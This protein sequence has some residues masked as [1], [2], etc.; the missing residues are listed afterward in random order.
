[1]LLRRVFTTLFCLLVGLGGMQAHGAEATYSIIGPMELKD[2]VDSGADTFLVIDARNPEE[3][4]EVHIPG[5][6]NVPQKK[7]KANKHLLPADKN[8]LLILYCNG[9]KCGKSKKAAKLAAQEGYVHI[10]VFAQGMPV[11]EEMNYPIAHCGV[12]KTAPSHTQ[13]ALLVRP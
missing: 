2:L 10:K 1:M 13:G 4:Q 7:F 8:K 9:V 6:I 11:W 3:Y 5:A 12:P